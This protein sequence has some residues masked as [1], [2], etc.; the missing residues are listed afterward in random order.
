MPLLFT[1]YD[2]YLQSS[3]SFQICLNWIE[4]FGCQKPTKYVQFI[5]YEAVKNNMANSKEKS[6]NNTISS[7][8]S[9]ITVLFEDLFE[10]VNIQAVLCGP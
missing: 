10:A 3:K 9:L 8:L 4:K 5:F 1:S 6:F 7:T 2:N